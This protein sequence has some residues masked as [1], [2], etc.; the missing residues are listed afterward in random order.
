MTTSTSTVTFHPCS[1]IHTSVPLIRQS[2]TDEWPAVGDSLYVRISTKA[3]F[4]GK[5]TCQLLAPGDVPTTADYWFLGLCAEAMSNA[6]DIVSTGTT[7]KFVSVAISG[8][9]YTKDNMKLTSA[10]SLEPKVIEC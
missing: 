10:K 6:N 5:P 7:I 8:L 3:Y 2:E 9:A 4:Y 1:F